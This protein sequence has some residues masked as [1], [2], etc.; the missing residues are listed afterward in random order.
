MRGLTTRWIV[1]LTGLLLFVGACEDAP[2]GQA[3]G[4]DL[5]EPSALI[6]DAAHSGGVENFYF[7]PP[8]VPN[9]AVAGVFDASFSPTVEICQLDGSD[10]AASQPTGFPIVYTMSTGPGGETVA[11]SAAD[12]HYKVNWH[13]DEFT[14]NETEL[15]RISV[16]L[17]GNVIGFADVDVVNSGKDLKN[18]DTNEFIAL[19]DGRTLPIK[20]RLEEGAG[21]CTTLPGLVAWWAGDG[22]ADDII[23]SADGSLVGNTSFVGGLSNQAFSFDGSGDYVSA[24]FAFAGPFTVDQPVLPG[25][26]GAGNGSMPGTWSSRFRSERPRPRGSTSPMTEQT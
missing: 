4:F 21:V 16:L 7:L 11:V 9:P 22:N 18:V 13:T 5:L 20:F 25:V 24:P 10:C 17:D 3:D 23:G 8:M 2:L 15:Y 6:E 26:D 1:T 19:K 14:L 12:E